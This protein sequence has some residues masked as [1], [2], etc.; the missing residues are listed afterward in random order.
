MY[1]KSFLGSPPCSRTAKLL[2]LMHRLSS[3]IASL[4]WNNREVQMISKWYFSRLWVRQRLALEAWSAKSQGWSLRNLREKLIY[5]L[6]CQTKQNVSWKTKSLPDAI[7]L[8]AI[9]LILWLI[10]FLQEDRRPLDILETSTHHYNLTL[11]LLSD[12][13]SIFWQLHW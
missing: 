9:G 3:L 2:H 4:E 13:Y 12:V 6:F 11:C 7:T 8:K 1:W 10:G 5:L